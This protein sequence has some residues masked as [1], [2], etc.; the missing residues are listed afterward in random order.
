MVKRK[1]ENGP[2]TPSTG[3]D[4]M[5]RR[6]KPLDVL[7]GGTLSMRD[8]ADEYLPRHDK[9]SY[10][11]W[12][13]RRDRS[14]LLP[15]YDEALDT[16]C[17][18]PFSRPMSYEGEL[19]P[20][21]LLTWNDMDQQG[22]DATTFTKAWFREGWHRGL[23]HIL[24]DSPT[25]DIPNL[26]AQQDSGVRPYAT[27][28]S[29]RNLFAWRTKVI[30]GIGERLTH[31]RFYE[32]ALE[33]DG[34]GDR[35]VKRIREFN[36]PTGMDT[37]SWKTFEE[38]NG[39]WV[40]KETGEF[41]HPA[42]IPLATF[43]V[44]RRGPMLARP[45]LEQIGH[46]NIR[47]FQ[48]DSEQ[49]DLLQFARVGVWFARGWT[50]K[51]LANGLTVGANRF[52]GTTNPDGSLEVV[53]HTG[54]AIEAGAKDIDRLEARMDGLVQ[55]QLASQ[56][57][58]V[59]ATAH[60]LAAGKQQ[61][62]VGQSIMV[63]NAVSRRVFD[64]VA[65]FYNGVKVPEKFRPR[66]FSDFVVSML[67][68]TDVPSILEMRVNRDLSRRTTFEELQRRSFLSDRVDADEEE[69]RLA[70]EATEDIRLGI[71]QPPQPPD[72]PFGDGVIDNPDAPPAGSKKGK[73]AA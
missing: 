59:K 10:P 30:K 51:E 38:V 25:V 42:G 40:V 35:E 23:V 6:W 9:E 12:E 20:E 71:G 63:A 16:I 11:K 29:A 68:G 60:A 21:L 22:N 66:I 5:A 64:L 45:P 73:K 27:I 69:R 18:K 26:K 62:R 44:D 56:P 24:V 28:I 58:D 50:E 48:S 36:S 33:P 70:E 34:Y 39:E 55:E 37:C 54:A 49:Q 43:Y 13:R 47:H 1:I 7:L 61:S 15:K 17:A 65:G 72:R 4:D 52:V 67:G 2:D 41:E 14:V 19:P 53:E 31:I 8:H 3:W 57:G 46:L 32:C